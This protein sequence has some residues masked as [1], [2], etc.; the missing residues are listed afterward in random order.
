[1]EKFIKTCSIIILIL[2]FSMIIIMIF[3]DAEKIPKYI[4]IEYI[5]IIVVFQIYAIR[6][7]LKYKNIN[8]LIK[9][10]KYELLIKKIEKMKNLN[11]IF[12]QELV[13][14]V[15]YLNVSGLCLKYNDIG[16]FEKYIDKVEHVKLKLI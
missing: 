6:L 14:Q 16:N 8:K 3:F 12:N 11:I 5:A 7:R 4:T 2:I 9:K 1:M 15:L 13:E 10:D